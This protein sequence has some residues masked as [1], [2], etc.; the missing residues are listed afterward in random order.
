MWSYSLLSAWNGSPHDLPLL[1]IYGSDTLYSLQK[2]ILKNWNTKSTLFIW[3]I[4]KEYNN[5]A[6]FEITKHVMNSKSNRN[7]CFGSVAP[8]KILRNFTWFLM[9][10]NP[11]FRVLIWKIQSRIRIRGSALK[12][13][14]KLCRRLHFLGF[15]ALQQSGVWKRAS[16]ALVVSVRSIAVRF[17]ENMVAAWARCR[18]SWQISARARRWWSRA[19]RE[20][21][22]DSRCFCWKIA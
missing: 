7:P 10:S 11:E 9:S 8:E 5:W 1:S 3:E 4:D 6:L 12:I 15:E 13:W 17:A 22:H 16:M 2:Y 21:W 20:V 19:R 14:K 18:K